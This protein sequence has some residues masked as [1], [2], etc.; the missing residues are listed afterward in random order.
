MHTFFAGATAASG[1]AVPA[2]A[3]SVLVSDD[4][5]APSFG[6]A[7]GGGLRTEPSVSCMHAGILKMWMRTQQCRLHEATVHMQRTCRFLAFTAGFCTVLA[8]T[9]VAAASSACIIDTLMV[10]YR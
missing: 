9:A 8:G 1:T 3:L 10:K 5:A 2:A 7:P 4:W 6:A